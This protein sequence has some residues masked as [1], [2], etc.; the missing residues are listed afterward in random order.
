VIFHYH[1]T[2]MN[3]YEEFFKI[4]E[5]LNKANVPYAVVGGIALSFHTEPRYTKDIDLLILPE[6]I[7][8]AKVVL[9]DLGYDFEAKPWKFQNSNITLHRISKIN[10]EDFSTVDLLEGHDSRLTEVVKNAV[11]EE[12]QF[13]KVS[14]A[15]KEDLIWMK[16]LRN[17]KQDIADIEALENESY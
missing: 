14:I 12:T 9:H 8:H 10:G 1:L 4:I 5:G 13:G 7:N 15:V 16:K 17:S 2:S 11:Q 6:G 3:I